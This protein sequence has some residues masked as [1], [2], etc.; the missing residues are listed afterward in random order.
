MP[1]ARGAREALPDGAWWRKMQRRLLVRL[2]SPETVSDAMLVLLSAAA[3]CVDA[4]S[5]LGLGHIFT[6]NMTGN[7]V[8]LGLPLGQADWQA[9]LGSSV[10]LVGFIMGV[11]VG[12]VIAGRDQ[13]GRAVWPM[14]VT[15]TLTVEL[16]V[17]GAFALGLYLAGGASHTLILLAA[18]AMGLQSTAV[19][20]LGIPGVAT[21]YITGNPDR[22]DRRGDQQVVPCD[23]LCRDA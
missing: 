20:R 1:P 12:A 18:L 9:A 17:L 8:L 2:S 7:T 23:L 15:V 5:Y 11:A 13:K 22:R 6:A 4:V 16:A 19:R 14:T 21:T 10:A 3:G